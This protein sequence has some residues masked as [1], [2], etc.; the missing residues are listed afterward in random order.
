MFHNQAMDWPLSREEKKHQLLRLYNDDVKAADSMVESGNKALEALR[1]E[2]DAVRRA[3]GVHQVAK[4][5]TADTG[6]SHRSPDDEVERLRQAVENAAAVLRAIVPLEDDDDEATMHTTPLRSRARSEGGE[7]ELRAVALR[8]ALCRTPRESGRP[9][10]KVS[11]GGQPE[12]EPA[13][14]PSVGSDADEETTAPPLILQTPPKRKDR[15]GKAGISSRSPRSP[16]PNAQSK[17]S[18]FT[19]HLTWLLCSLGLVALCGYGAFK[20]GSNQTSPTSS[21]MRGDASCWN[22]GFKPE[23]CCDTAKGPKGR[24]ECWDQ[25]FTFERCC[26]GKK[27]L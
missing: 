19:L 27:E 21:P 12:Q 5:K 17:S 24:N 4:R 23:F 6:A 16:P 9:K 1:E 8:P 10:R 2:L 15:N 18:S 11:F 14:D 22:L 13:P 20:Q 7:R 3:A 26:I 25:E